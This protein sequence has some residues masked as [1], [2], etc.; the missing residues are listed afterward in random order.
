MNE[1]REYYRYEINIPLWFEV[2][3]IFKK[4]FQSKCKMIDINPK[5]ILFEAKICFKVEKL[6][7]LRFFLPLFSEPVRAL[8]QV[9]WT[10]EEIPKNLYR[11][12]AEFLDIKNAE[13]SK[14]HFLSK[15]YPKKIAEV[16]SNKK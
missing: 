8:A 15:E 7:G 14:F 2:E 3:P 16:V 9:I 13:E 6:L 4:P 12:G 5:G 11:T 10:K 1:K